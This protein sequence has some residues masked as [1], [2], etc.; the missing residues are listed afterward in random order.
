[1]AAKAETQG[2]A[3]LGSIVTE[4]KAKLVQV[5]MKTEVGA[6]GQEKPIETKNGPFNIK[7]EYTECEAEEVDLVNDVNDGSTGLF[8]VGILKN[9]A[10]VFKKEHMEDSILKTSWM[11]WK[12]SKWRVILGIKQMRKTVNKNTMLSK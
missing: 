11:F 5:K 8:S 4:K 12:T 7:R 6:Y 2:N 9:D 1:M 3:V 10:Y